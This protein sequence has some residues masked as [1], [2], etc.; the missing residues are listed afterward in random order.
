[1][2]VLAGA[3]FAVALIASNAGAQ[4]V[5]ETR[6]SLG[7]RVGDR[8]QDVNNAGLT[9]DRRTSRRLNTRINSRLYTR[10]DRFADPEAD[11]SDRPTAKADDGTKKR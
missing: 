11:R 1:M 7:S 5:D 3:L 8:E 6:K 4:D 2:R 10:I 9:G